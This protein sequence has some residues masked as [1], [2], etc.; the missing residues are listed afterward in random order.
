[1]QIKKILLRP[2]YLKN[3]EQL[4]LKQTTTVVFFIYCKIIVTILNPIS[5]VK[6]NTI[7]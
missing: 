2:K 1:M 4:Y 5:S 7:N 3:I 6:R